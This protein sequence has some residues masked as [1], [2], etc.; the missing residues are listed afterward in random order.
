MKTLPICIGLA[1]TAVLLGGKPIPVHAD[2][3]ECSNKSPL[4]ADIYGN[5]LTNKK[6]AGVSITADVYIGNSRTGKNVVVVG[7]DPD[8][9]GVTINVGLTSVWGYVLHDEPDFREVCVPTYTDPGENTCADYNPDTGQFYKWGFESY[10]HKNIATPAIRPVKSV[11][12]WLQ[13]SDET[14]EW[15]NWNPG[16][17]KLRSNLRLIYPEK[18]MAGT[19]T[20]DGFTVD[21]TPDIDASWS[22]SYYEAWKQQLQDYNFLAGDINKISKLWSVT[23]VELQNPYNS[24]ADSL[25]IFGN[26]L[27]GPN[28]ASLVTNSYMREESYNISYGMGPGEMNEHKKN[29]LENW[30]SSSPKS[31]IPLTEQL[32]SP[33]QRE[34]FTITMEHIP[35]DLPGQWFIGV[36]VEMGP[37]IFSYK[38]VDKEEGV[39]ESWTGS[40]LGKWFS[41][42]QVDYEMAD[43][44][45]YAYVLLSTPCNPM[46]VDNCFDTTMP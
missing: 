17:S 35:I 11:L 29:R 13:P 4:V 14:A 46:E 10:C 9:I 21:Q 45:F 33:K 19:W 38:G 40:P 20:P 24:N 30:A 5:S 1:I 34:S 39:D 15:L 3:E 31:N 28:A 41:P 44:Y 22:E 26:F 32:Q 27:N 8:E 42:E 37:A 6:E 2:A 43:H 16:Q 25:G 36:Y 12:I 7:Q 23:M 18:W